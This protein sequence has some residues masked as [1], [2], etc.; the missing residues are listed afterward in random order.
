M[1]CSIFCNIISAQHSD[2]SKTQVVCGESWCTVILGVNNSTQNHTEGML[3]TLK[4]VLC[5]T[6][7]SIIS[8]VHPD[9]SKSISS[10]I[11]GD[12]GHCGR[13]E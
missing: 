12:I 3:S 9:K 11:L 1:L 13:G 10:V 5:S 2:N 8:A 6:F 4:E 7:C